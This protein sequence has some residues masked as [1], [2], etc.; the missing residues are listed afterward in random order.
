MTDTSTVFRPTARPEERA[1][2]QRARR[3]RLLA[4]ADERVRRLPVRLLLYTLG[5]SI[6]YY[7]VDFI[8]ALLSYIILLTG[9]AVDCLALRTV[10]RREALVGSLNRGQRWATITSALQGITMVAGVSVYYFQL[11]EDANILFVIGALGLGAVNAAIVLPKN[12]TAAFTRLTFYILA[13]FLYVSLQSIWTKSWTPFV[14][15]DVAGTMLVFCMLYM[16]LAFTKSGINNFKITQDLERQKSEMKIM[17]ARMDRHQTELQQLSLVARHAND[18][19]IITDRERRIVW[20]NDAFTRI[21]GFTFADAKG[22]IVADLL[23]GADQEL[24]AINTIDLAVEAGQPFRGEVQNVTRDGNRIWLDVN[25]FPVDGPDGEPEYYV[26]IER[27]VT[28]SR[29]LAEQMSKARQAAEEGARAKAEFLANM[30]HEI[31]TPLTG[32]IGMADLLSETNLDED[33]GRYTDTIRG[34]SQALMAI[35]NDILDL[36]KLDAGRMELHPVSFSPRACLQETLDLLM[37]AARSKGLE[38]SL[39]VDDLAPE[40]IKAD[41]GRL[42]QVVTN[43]VGNAIKFTED[44]GVYITLS[45]AEDSRGKRL[46]CE[47]TDTG[48]GISKENQERIFDHFSQAEAA[49][50]RKFGGTGLGLSISKHILEVM[51]G[52]ISVDSEVG[53]G[54][55]F[56]LEIPYEEADLRRE[57]TGSLGH[58]GPRKLLPGLRVV[59]AEDNKTNRF[60]L[61]KFFGDQPV[62]LAFA[63]DGVE[64]VEVV[65]TFAPD[66]VLMDM[67][68]PRKSGLDATREIRELPIDQPAIVA[69]TAHAFDEEMQA[70]L[71][72]GMDDFLTKPIRKAVLID[73]IAQFQSR[74]MVETKS[75]MKQPPITGAA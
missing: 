21:T 15:M 49:T 47:V 60:L 75:E 59:V 9:D 27:D 38:L 61:K 65:Q 40:F 16:F 48:I 58:E 33:Q 2:D 32:V 5:C 43:I 67:S 14:M 50:T 52:A 19:V 10:V 7:A 35:I 73:W 68:M 39:R 44:G 42:R 72:A 20:V 71:D 28:E 22:Q 8:P 18:S 11:G 31:R 29:R 64:A 57:M 1:A 51:G 45:H 26:S 70:C 4:Y 41:D 13:P 30:S 3:K 37:P 24:K 69:L 53:Q 54:A 36:S 12:P 34:S 46:I 56:H 63:K 55:T 25:L 23:T 6:G 66:L 74:L 17:Y 62:E